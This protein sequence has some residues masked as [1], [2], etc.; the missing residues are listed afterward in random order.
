MSNTAT[1]SI[2]TN[3]K[4]KQQAQEFFE[5]LWISL[6]AGINLLLKDVAH[7][8]RFRFDYTPLQLIEV[9]ESGL[10]D[11]VRA[12]YEEAENMSD[13]DFITIDLSDE[14]SLNT[15]FSQVDQ[16]SSSKKSLEPV[17]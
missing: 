2:R 12:S 9:D 17:S 3:A 14:D 13:D 15:Y 8:Q 6:T 4:V 11:E 5:S 7:N 10:S 16:V 1:I